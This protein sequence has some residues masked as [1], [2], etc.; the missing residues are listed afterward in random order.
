MIA[1]IFP[2]DRTPV[3]LGI[4]LPTN[5]LLQLWNPAFFL[6]KWLKDETGSDIR[7]LEWV[8]LAAGSCQRGGRAVS[9]LE[10]QP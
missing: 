10:L 8:T 3:M 7:Q 5:P 6:T 1:G 4:D 9:R 2:V